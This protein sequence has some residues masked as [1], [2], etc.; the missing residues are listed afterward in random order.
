VP[1]NAERGAWH[2]R[3]ATDN[4]LRTG[5]S[6]CAGGLCC[7]LE[8]ARKS[9][10]NAARRLAVSRWRRRSPSLLGHILDM[11]VVAPPPPAGAPLARSSTRH[12]ETTSGHSERSPDAPFAVGACRKALQMAA[13]IAPPHGRQVPWTA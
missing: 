2:H 6:P 1:G 10:H 9:F 12:Y 3:A 7:L 13:I 11:A 5:A 4:R 8:R